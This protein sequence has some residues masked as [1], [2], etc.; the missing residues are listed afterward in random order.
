MDISV[1]SL[2]LSSVTA[3]VAVIGPIV[4]SVITLKSNESLKRLDLYSPRVYEA[5]QKFMMLY[6]KIPRYEDLEWKTELEFSNACK[7]A[8]G[9]IKEFIAAGYEV[10]S[11]M[12]NE[13]IQQNLL[14]L[15]SK[16]QYRSSADE[17]TDVLF[18]DVIKSIAPT[19]APNKSKRKKC[20]SRQKK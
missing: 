16:M 6:S 14:S 18:Y 9:P 20:K 2:I 13:N 7:K 8:R 10:A 4:S 5:A 17:D 1:I 12:P 19:L 15:I 3:I 11:L